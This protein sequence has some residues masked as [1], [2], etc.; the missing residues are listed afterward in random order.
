ML[1]FVRWDGVT[2]HDL[3]MRVTPLMTRLTVASEDVFNN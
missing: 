2:S 3:R 1:K